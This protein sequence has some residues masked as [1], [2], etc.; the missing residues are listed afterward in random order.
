VAS[1]LRAEPAEP[2][3]VVGWRAADEVEILTLAVDP[4][5][6]GYYSDGE[7]ALVYGAALS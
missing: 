3:F 2:A 1:R 5:Y 6:R 7:D 4:A